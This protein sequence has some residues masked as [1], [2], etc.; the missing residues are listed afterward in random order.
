[1]NELKGL[2]KVILP[3]KSGTSKA[4]KD[5]SKQEFVIET[6]DK[7]PKMVAF[8]LFNKPMEG[9]VGDQ[10][11]VEFFPESREFNGK[12]YTDLMAWRVTVVNV[13]NEL[14][15]KEEAYQAQ[16]DDLPF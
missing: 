8:T 5:W 4:G 1:M 3:V 7:F 12:Y 10:A 16:E 9:R 11:T 2:I 13:G 6:D 14:E 15:P